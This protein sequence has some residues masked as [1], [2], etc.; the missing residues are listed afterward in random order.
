MS[1]Q[2]YEDD[3][4][5]DLDINNDVFSKFDKLESMDSD[6]DN[7]PIQKHNTKIGFNQKPT[8]SKNEN[9]ILI[10]V[11]KKLIFINNLSKEAFI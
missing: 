10:K 4:D 9:K 3:V 11:K 7:E 1:T 6:S 2:K 5:N 8:A